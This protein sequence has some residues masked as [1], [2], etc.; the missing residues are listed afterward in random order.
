MIQ[1][2]VSQTHCHALLPFSDFGVVQDAL[3]P[4]HVCKAALAKAKGLF[5]ELCMLARQR[6]SCRRGF[7][8]LRN[9]GDLLLRKRY[10]CL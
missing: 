6:R 4:H 5:N 3:C 7:K 2:R 10:I 1:T 9:D 8:R